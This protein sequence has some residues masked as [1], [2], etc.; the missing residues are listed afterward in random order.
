MKAN[1]KVQIFLNCKFECLPKLVVVMVKYKLISSINF[2]YILYPFI[3]KDDTSELEK[4]ISDFL[5][6]SSAIIHRTHNL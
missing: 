4:T 6:C 3:F 1:W 5:S 2:F